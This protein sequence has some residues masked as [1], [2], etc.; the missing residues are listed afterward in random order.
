MHLLW[1]LLTKQG[2]IL[3]ICSVVTG[4]KEF[5][6]SARRVRKVWMALHNKAH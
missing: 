5:I 1:L 6:A 4:S 2:R 3:V